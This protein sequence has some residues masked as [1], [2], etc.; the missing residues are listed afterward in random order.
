ML[1]GGN[2]TPGTPLTKKITTTMDGAKTTKKQ[3]KVKPDMSTNARNE[4]ERTWW[5]ITKTEIIAG[6][7]NIKLTDIKDVDKDPRDTVEFIRIKTE[8]DMTTKER[9][10]RRGGSNHE[11]L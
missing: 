5:N 6:V 10:T 7:P 1:E 11:R 2:D 4:I 8:E 9:Q 3:G